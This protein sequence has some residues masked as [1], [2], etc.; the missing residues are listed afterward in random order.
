M[1]IQEP[2]DLWE[3]TVDRIQ[4]YALALDHYAQK[5]P[6]KAM[7]T[8]NELVISGLAAQ[9]F[10]IIPK[11]EVILNVDG[12]HKVVI[13]EVDT[14][15]CACDLYFDAESE[16]MCSLLVFKHNAFDT[17]EGHTPEILAQTDKNMPGVWGNR[18][19]VTPHELPEKIKSFFCLLCATIVRDFWVL[20]HATRQKVYQNRTEKVRER[21]GTGKDRHLQITK[22]HRYIPRVRYDLSA[23]E[24]TDRKVS[25]Q[26]RVTLSP[27]LV[28]GHLRQLPKGHT[29][30]EKAKQNA[31]EYGVILAPGVTFVSPHEKGQV[32]QMR[33][34][35]SRSA[36]EL[37]F[38]ASG[39]REA[40]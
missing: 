34:Y 4:E 13:D 7:E 30:S 18:L 1:N 20:N 21:V 37:I 11:S 35:R 19:F 27:H 23:Y 8:A 31:A 39:D 32:E 12:L 36:L 26:V 33:T 25:E 14:D 5:S 28:S 2:K 3:R 16:I 22:I 9:H 17:R 40:N 38:K 29:A 6:E 24:G 15:S 10:T